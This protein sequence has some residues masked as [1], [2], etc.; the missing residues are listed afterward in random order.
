MPTL[1]LDGNSEV[2]GDVSFSNPDAQLLMDSNSKIA[3]LRKG[4]G[5]LYEHIH[6]GVPE[7]EFPTVSTA[8]FLPYATNVLTVVGKKYDSG[9][10]KNIR[11]KAGTNPEFDSNIELQ[12][13]IYIETPNHVKFSSNT[14][15]T[16]AIVVQDNPTGD[17]TTNSILFSSNARIL[18][19]DT[20]P[21]TAD[22]PLGLRQL[23]GA[24]I[25]A[26]KFAVTFNSNFG[27]TGGSIIAGKMHFD[28][29]ADGTV[30]G[31]V[32]NLE[33]TMVQMDSNAEIT[34]ESQGTSNY[35]AG[36]SFGSRFAP[37]PDTYREVRR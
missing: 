16:G 34:I 3:G 9:V 18:P 35:P 5:E 31:S 13:I 36:V 33:D 17:V 21:A 15:I 6:Y 29:N 8:A 37:L 20:L 32:I 12:G 23:T 2:S 7:P 14:K 10:L 26:P 24:T 22:F 25:L 4:Q 11:I 27:S 19:I 1:D 28:S 30:K